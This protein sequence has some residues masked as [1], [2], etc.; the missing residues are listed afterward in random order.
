MLANSRDIWERDYAHLA[1]HK[2]GEK[3][4]A[5]EGKRRTLSSTNSAAIPATEKFDP[6]AW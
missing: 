6:I 1:P 3:R 4:D 5:F 2:K